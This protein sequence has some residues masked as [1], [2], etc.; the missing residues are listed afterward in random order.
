LFK[1]L[2]HQKRANQLNLLLGGI[3]KDYRNIGINAVI[4]VK[5]IEEACKAGLK[6]VDSYLELEANTRMR[7]EMERLNGKVYKRY[8]IYKKEL[9][10]K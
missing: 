2:Y 7:A 10:A 6:Y 5:M 9:A 8:R 3:R 4:G 1:I